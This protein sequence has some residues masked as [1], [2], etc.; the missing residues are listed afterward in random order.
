MPE[1][2]PP[3]FNSLLDYVESAR[4]ADGLECLLLT[5]LNETT[6]IGDQA[7]FERSLDAWTNFGSHPTV[8][9]AGPLVF[10]DLTRRRMSIFSRATSQTLYAGQSNSGILTFGSDIG[11]G[12]ERLAE[13]RLDNPFSVAVSRPPI[14]PR[15]DRVTQAEAKFIAGGA[16]IGAAWAA[17][18]TVLLML[19]VPDPL[20]KTAGIIM[21]LAGTAI[22]LVVAWQAYQIASRPLQAVDVDAAPDG[23]PVDA[24]YGVCSQNDLT[25]SAGDVGINYDGGPSGDEGGGG[26]EQHYLGRE[27]LF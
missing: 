17:G 18:G 14:R 24:G 1:Y 8:P 26:G 13:I 11:Q 2:R 9:G 3:L 16:L 5:L 10:Y 23:G 20:T 7:T 4:S 19:P 15:D 6:K 27:E 21:L 12:L 22:T 25:S